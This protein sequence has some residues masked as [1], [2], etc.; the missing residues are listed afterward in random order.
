MDILIFT[1]KMIKKDLQHFS[2]KNIV[3]TTKMKIS[4]PVEIVVEIILFLQFYP[5]TDDSLTYTSFLK[6]II[7]WKELRKIESKELQ[8]ELYSRFIFVNFNINKIP[9]KWAIGKFI[10]AHKSKVLYTDVHK[11]SLRYMDKLVSINKDLIDRVFMST[12]ICN[13]LYF[14]SVFFLY[15]SIDFFEFIIDI[16]YE[17]VKAGV[18]Y[19]NTTGNKWNKLEF[20]RNSSFTEL[21][22]EYGTCEQ[23]KLF[24]KKMDVNYIDFTLLLHSSFVRDDTYH[25]LR[26]YGRKYH[27][28]LNWGK[29]EE[30][31]KKL[32]FLLVEAPGIPK[33][34][35]YLGFLKILVRHGNVRLIKY[36]LE[37]LAIPIDHQWIHI[38]YKHSDRFTVENLLV[39]W[40]KRD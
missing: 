26:S 20:M 27:L 1:K 4:L 28:I 12:T 15:D 10:V 24:T 13:F 3:D 14:I 22:V 30:H 5:E 32:E 35:N 38:L 8:E 25:F 11:N 7:T 19:T 16:F 21:I 29:I 17:E 6:Q 9:K 34:F 18:E 40:K 36:L 39:E 37:F 2:N 33:P 23:L 31:Y